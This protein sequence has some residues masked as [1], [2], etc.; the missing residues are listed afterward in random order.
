MKSMNSAPGDVNLFEKWFKELDGETEHIVTNAFFN[1]SDMNFERAC[2]VLNQEQARS[3]IRPGGLID[4]YMQAYKDAA[5]KENAE[6]R[7]ETLRDLAKDVV[8]YISRRSDE[9]LL[10]TE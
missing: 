2:Q 1:S 7:R 6:K 3:L 9:D 8:D 10:K 4:L 5:L